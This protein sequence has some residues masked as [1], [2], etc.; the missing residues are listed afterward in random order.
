[1]STYEHGQFCWTDLIVPDVDAA[2]PFYGAL[3]GWSTIQPP[4]ADPGVYLLF[5][6][7]GAD[8]AGLYPLK[9]EMAADGMHPC[10]SSYVAVDRVDA[11]I[12]RITATG[13]KLLQGPIEM[14]DV[15]TMA[16]VS[17]PQGAVFCLWQADSPFPGAARLGLVPGTMCWNELATTDP[18]AARGFYEEL[19]RWSCQ[20]SAATAETYYEFANA[21]GE[22]RG[23]MLPIGADWGPVPP[24]WLVYFTVEDCDR[25]VALAMDRG[26]QT[27][28]APFDIPGVGRIAV[29]AD[30]QGA[31]F[32]IAALSVGG[33]PAA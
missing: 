8:I 3:F 25:S 23:G 4:A 31:V 29:L 13:G 2:K 7:K 18:A 9:P 10:W 21:A 6:L 17:D 33:E 5:Q 19:L 14:T 27:I 30:P 24:H 12:E 20:A 1:M 22:I 11:A 16:V 26:G 28:R 15:G 32:A